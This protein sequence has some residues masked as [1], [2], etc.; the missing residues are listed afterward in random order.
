MSDSDHEEPPNNGWFDSES[1]LPGMSS[2]D[3]ILAVGVNVSFPSADRQVRVLDFG[4]SNTTGPAPNTGI[5][6]GH[7]P[8]RG[9]G[10]GNGENFLDAPVNTPPRSKSPSPIPFHWGLL[11]GRGR[12]MGREGGPTRSS[13]L[14]SE[15]VGLSRSVGIGSTFLPRFFVGRETYPSYVESTDDSP[16]CAGRYVDRQPVRNNESSSDDNKLRDVLELIAKRLD[17][18]ENKIYFPSSQP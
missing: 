10:F 17:N 6:V 2:V 3:S 14:V 18:L 16:P 11:M 15:A 8:L 12:R 1:D 13:T 9:T 5:R 4:N 7:A